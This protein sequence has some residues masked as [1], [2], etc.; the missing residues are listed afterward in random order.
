MK[1][2]LG[3]GFRVLGLGVQGLGFRNYMVYELSGFNLGLRGF[4]CKVCRACGL[5]IEC[6]DPQPHI[7]TPKTLGFDI[8]NLG[9]QDLVL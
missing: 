9:V 8:C 6:L 5:R 1:G 7:F 2:S 3:L 4:G